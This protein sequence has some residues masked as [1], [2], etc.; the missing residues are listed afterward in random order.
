VFHVEFNL[1]TG[2]FCPQANALNFNSMK[3]NA[4]LDAARWPC[5]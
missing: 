5:R 2:A 3:K 4:S 1:E